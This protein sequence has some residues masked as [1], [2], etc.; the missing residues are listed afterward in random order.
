MNRWSRR[1]F[2]AM[3]L[4][5]GCTGCQ[6]VRLGINESDPDKSV[7]DALKS[8]RPG[9]HPLEGMRR[10]GMKIAIAQGPLKDPAIDRSIWNTAD[11]QVIDPSLRETLR[12]NG[13]RFGILR[14]SL[15]LDVEEALKHSG[16]AGQTVEPLEVNQPANEPTKI[17]TGSKKSECSVLMD[18]GGKVQGKTYRNLSGFLRVSGQLDAKSNV[19]LKVV[20]ELH[21]G[22]IKSSFSASNAADNP[23]EPAQLTM[24]SGQ[25]EEILRE[26]ALNV[27]IEPDQCL[28][29]GL[30]SNREGSLGWLLL[31]D[32]PTEDQDTRQRMILIWAWNASRDSTEPSDGSGRSNLARSN[33][34]TFDPL[35]PPV[36]AAKKANDPEPPRIARGT[37]DD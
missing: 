28:V 26:L 30:D 18:A 13:L 23:F 22:D 34:K 7:G 2:F 5:L 10:V 20:P 15:P 25:T 8:T 19:V 9:V 4:S 1:R 3:S 37:S 6:F 24:R 32:P 17:A 21:H 27:T 33:P 12:N 11:D 36:E 35:K 29:I 31:T 16:P 14:S